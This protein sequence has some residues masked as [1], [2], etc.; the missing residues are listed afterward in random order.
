MEYGARERLN[1]ARVDT[2]GQIAALT[3]D[4]H[5]VMAAA[6]VVAT[7]DEHDPEGATIAF[8]RAQVAAL[9]DQARQRL[10]DLDDALARLDQGSYGTCAGCGRPIDP[11]RLV[12]RPAARTCITCA[13]RR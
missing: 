4:L 12:A 9:L 5:G 2:V 3:A 8:E 7:D 6:Y 1:A 11:E 13:A 10:A